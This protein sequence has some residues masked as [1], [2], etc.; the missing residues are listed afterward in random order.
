[1]NT[2]VCVLFRQ[3]ILRIVCFLLYNHRYNSCGG[4]IEV[5]IKGYSLQ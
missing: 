1:M 4:Q 3:R 5:G 2:V